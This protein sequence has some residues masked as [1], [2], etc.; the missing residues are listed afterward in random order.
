MA[1]VNAVNFANS[2]NP[3]LSNRNDPGTVGGRVRSL[4]DNIE[5]SAQAANDTINIGKILSAGAIIHDVQIDNDALGAG[6]I[7]DVGDSND[8]DRYINGYD[9]EANLTNKGAVSPVTGEMQIDGVHYA[10]GTN[11]GD[12]TIRVTILV[13]AA[14]GTL[15]VTIY[16]SED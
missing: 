13:A 16:Y 9:A 2:L 10:I 4:T 8:P 1:N 6:V 12:S 14:T 11:T 7:L 3:S 15:K 5:L